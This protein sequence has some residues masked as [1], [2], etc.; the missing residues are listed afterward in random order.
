VCADFVSADSAAQVRRGAFGLLLRCDADGGVE[1]VRSA[2]AAEPPDAVFAP[3][4]IA[5]IA[6][7]RGRRVSKEFGKLMPRLAP[8]LQ[9]LL[10]EALACRADKDARAVIRAQLGA[11]DP[12]VR[13][14]AIDAVGKLEDESAVAGLVQAFAAAAT[15]EEEKAIQ[16]SLASLSG[17]AATDKA[18]VAAVRRATG[19]EQA[20]LIDVLARRGGGAA[21][22][23]L[24]ELSGAPEEQ[25]ARA[26][27]QALARL[28]DSADNAS[29]AALQKAVAGDDARTREVAL[30]ALAAWRGLAAWD[31]LA[32]VYAK[33]ASEAQRALALRGLV[34]MA[35][36][37][38]AQ[39]DAALIGR[40]RQLLKGAQGDADNKLIL[41]MMGGVAHPDTLVL[42]LPLLA[43]AGVHAEA[44]QAVE[45]IAQAI[46]KSHP[47][48]ARDAL[49]KV[50]GG[51]H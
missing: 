13:Q 45:R 4:A 26:A 25:A 44:A 23:V 17:G 15:P 29:L 35:G 20:L 6:G 36:E 9:V 10:V 2:L 48:A 42:A 30:R 19:K 28:A 51:G 12:G 24:L 22:P 33:P 50:K 7:L 11:A 1:R 32:G 37:G 43:Q 27:A 31:T 46:Q 5:H 39:P 14:A 18:I 16:A 3:V 49:L 41:T 34:R 38:N 8:A 40:Y 47:D 21:V